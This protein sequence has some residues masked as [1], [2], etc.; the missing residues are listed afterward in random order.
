MNTAAVTIGAIL[1]LIAVNIGYAVITAVM[2]TM[3]VTANAAIAAGA[4]ILS[5][6][7]VTAAREI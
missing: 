4:D 6:T 2:V 7:A 5:E 1:T 3:T